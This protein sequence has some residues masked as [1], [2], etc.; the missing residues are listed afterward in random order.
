MF[1]E[2]FAASFAF[3]AFADIAGMV[4]FIVILLIVWLSSVIVVILTA[5]INLTEN[6]L[7]LSSFHDRFRIAAC[8]SFIIIGIIVLLAAIDKGFTIPDQK[9]HITL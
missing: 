6:P 7:S 2:F 4:G 8:I 5:E 1:E 9:N 3:R